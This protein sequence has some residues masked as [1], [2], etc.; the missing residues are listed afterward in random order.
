[1]TRRV[2]R[3]K[4]HMLRRRKSDPGHLRANLDAALDARAACEVDIRFSRDG[5]A[6]CLH[7]ATLDRETTGSGPADALTRAEIERLRQRAPDGTPVAQAP[8][9]LDEVASVVRARGRPDGGL[10]QLDVKAGVDALDAARLDRL[11]A[12]LGDIADRFVAG[13]CD[14]RM[15]V[16]LAAAIPGLKAGFDPL[17]FYPRSMPQGADAFRALA[18][19]TME[20]APDA[21][22]YY[23]EANLVLAGLD[24]GVNL[25]ETARRDGAEVDA[26]TIDADRPGLRDVLVRLVRA[27]ATQVTTNDPDLL[28]PLLEEAT[29]CA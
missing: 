1:M 12:T 2:P 29:A 26:W 11:R 14:W 16:R 17:D 3:L 8:L 27:G 22:I 18:R 28:G 15:P 23:L 4:W 10:V 24:C 19:R 6:L 5:H 9:F 7:D 20:T 13:A 21:S 25:I